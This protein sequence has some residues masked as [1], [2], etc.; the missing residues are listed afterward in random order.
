MQLRQLFLTVFL[1]IVFLAARGQGR[2][3]VHNFLPADYP[4]KTQNWAVRTD[5]NNLLWVAN[6][7]GLMTYNGNQWEII[8][9]AQRSTIRS[10][11]FGKNGRIYAGSISDFGYVGTD[12]IGRTRFQ[13]LIPLI[14]Q[15]VEFTDVW[16]TIAFGDTTVFLT[17]NYVFSYRDSTVEIIPGDYNYFYLA[18]KV[19]D[20]CIVQQIGGGLF[21]YRK[22][23]LIKINNSDFFKQRQVHSI[24]KFNDAYIIATKFH[25]LFKVKFDKQFLRIDSLESFST[26]VDG[27]ITVS[28]LYQAKPI[29]NDL[30][31]IATTNAG[32]FVIDFKGNLKYHFSTE[33]QLLTDA[34]YDFSC[35]KNGAVWLAQD[36]GLSLIELG[37]PV[38]HYD[39]KSGI[40]GTVSVINRF[41]GRY[42]VASG[43]G[44]FWLDPERPLH[45]RRFQKVS[46]ISMQSWNMLERG[47]GDTAELLVATAGGIFKIEKSSAYPVFQ[48]PDIY[49]M[50][51]PSNYPDHLLV[52]TRT[53]L[54]L[55][56]KKNNQW[57]KKHEFGDIRHQVRDIA[58]DTKGNVWIAANYKG[59][60]QLDV[61]QFNN[62]VKHQI[63]PVLD[64]KD[65]ANGINSLRPL[66]F[67]HAG[68]QLLFAVYPRLYTYD[69]PADQFK[70]LDLK[71]AG[72]DS[73]QKQMTGL[74][75]I[76]EK[77]IFIV[78]DK[79]FEIDSTTLMRLP[80]SVTHAILMDSSQVWI[81][82]ETGLYNYQVDDRQSLNRYFSIYFSALKFG[83]GPWNR[84]YDQ[85][86]P[87]K[88]ELDYSQNSISVTVSIPYFYNTPG[89][90]ISFYLKNFDKEFEPWNRQF[91]KS[92]TNLPPGNYTL[93]AQAKNTFGQKVKRKLLEVTI[94]PPIYQTT[95]AY[96]FYILVWGFVMYLAIRYR[97]RQLR[98]SKENLESVI[99]ERTQQLLDRNEE[100]MQVAEILKD[101]NKRLKELSIVAEKAGNA[102]A[103][104][105]KNGKL[106]Y[107]NAAF[108]KLYGYTCDEYTE[109][110]GVFLLENSEYPHIRNA[111]EQALKE[112]KSVQYEY[113]TLSK[114]HEGLWIHTTLTPVFNDQNEAEQFIAIDTNITQLKNA[115][116][117]VRFQKEELE[118]KS[119]ELAEKNQELQ[120]LSIIARETDNAVI[121][122][123]K[124]GSLLWVN[125]GYTR[126][127]GFTLED[128]RLKRGNVFN[129]SSNEKIQQYIKNWPEHRSSITYESQNTTRDGKKIWAQTT[130]TPIRKDDGEIDQIIA[131]DS[132][133][134]ALKRA[135][136][137]IE[138]QR[139]QLKTLNAT[140]DKFFSIIGHD[141]RSPFGNFVNMTN[142]IMQNIATADRPTLLNYVSK[143][144]RS[145]QNSYN[146]LENLLDWARH[147]QGR[148]KYYPD[149]EDTTAVVEEM[150]ELLMPLAERKKI[151]LNVNYE[152]PIYAYFDEHMIKTVVRNLLFNAL[153]FTPS[154]GRINLYFK[155]GNGQVSILVQDTG[156]GIRPEVQEKLFDTEA[157]FSTL[158]T[159]KERGTGLGLILSKD[160]VE[161]NGGTI[162]VESEPGKGSTFIVGIPNRPTDN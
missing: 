35:T 27:K 11:S 147:Q 36:M 7:D 110:K 48:Y 146:L 118:R 21:R 141:L 151:E 84:I 121:L 133:I 120:R 70:L 71:N 127:Y 126:L 77:T 145:A 93:Y 13:S 66:Q 72:Q 136:E 24:F 68:E 125:E 38:T 160:F 79:G 14:D 139:D 64:L 112:K 10:I 115:E 57:V 98:K 3:F 2:L 144:Q 31:G 90:R 73:L 29:C 148:I 103:I 9:T 63:A 123:D 128:L 94:E 12:S 89:N 92:Y 45:D 44:V 106:D 4:G 88:R 143:L 95:L 52:G 32:L 140:K 55:L 17:D 23:S 15:D 28:T 87:I 99:Q 78:R 56:Q 81:G 130:L 25:G 50:Y 49:S 114:S 43:F 22:D 76:S 34:V 83:D 119:K 85:S 75:N 116:E 80:Y 153:K 158:G 137:Q 69:Q 159:D 41:Q 74:S 5:S 108:E 54:L 37:L 105:D 100:I 107:C 19:S 149:F 82:T 18:H 47:S 16:S 135:E 131:I 33:N 142:L 117:E 134:T 155:E 46:N 8:Q 150:V 156:I 101:N 104:F 97:T 111:Y 161:M 1:L 40:K 132:D 51:T 91:K 58:E 60:Y 113:F 59:F 62:L 42:Y 109:E 152:E 122:T 20:H 61:T 6:Q 96:I 138:Q 129:M 39:Y 157:H 26:E 53:G 162:A 154:G 67:H 86:K 65:T 102:V 30:I 124:E